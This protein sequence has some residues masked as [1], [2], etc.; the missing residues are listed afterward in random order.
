MNNLYYFIKGVVETSKQMRGVRLKTTKKNLVC[1]IEAGDKKLN[2]HHVPDINRMG[3][4]F[5]ALHFNPINKKAHILVDSNFLEM[6]MEVQESILQH[7]V[8]HF[9]LGHMDQLASLKVLWDRYVLLGKIACAEGEEKDL[10]V[11]SVLATRDINHEMQADAYALKHSTEVGVLTMLVVMYAATHSSEL[12]AR[13]ENIAGE[14]PEWSLKGLLK[15]CD[16]LVHL[17]DLD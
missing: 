7:E 13:Y 10:L 16:S 5:A 8:G 11:Q 2:V 6:R 1:S 14:A 15:R 9:M 12:E 3:V 4:L 17:D